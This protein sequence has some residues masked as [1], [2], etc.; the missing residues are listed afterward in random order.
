MFFRGMSIFS[1]YFL[2]D[3]VIVV[4]YRIMAVLSEKDLAK[5]PFTVEETAEYFQVTLRTVQ[6]WI[7]DGTIKASKIGGV[8]RIS[9]NE[10]G[11]LMGEDGN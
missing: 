2:T 1:V 4:F 11:R 6:R 7:T 10:I 8:W 3:N 5:R 9:R